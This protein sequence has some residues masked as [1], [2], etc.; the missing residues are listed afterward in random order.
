MS[1]LSQSAPGNRYDAPERQSAPKDYE[2]PSMYH[3][4]GAVDTS[5][6]FLNALVA[7]AVAETRPV[8]QL[9]TIE[10]AARQVMEQAT[11]APAEPVANP[12]NGGLDVE[13]V[14]RAV[15]DAF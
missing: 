5:T 3:Y 7:R 6:G 13:T 11:A 12:A 1:Q 10:F 2:K 9:P 8:K 14:R 15:E 4:R